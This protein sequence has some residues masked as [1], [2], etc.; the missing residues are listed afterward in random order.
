MHFFCRERSTRER[1]MQVPPWSLCPGLTSVPE[2]RRTQIWG[3]F[4]P[5]SLFGILICSPSLGKGNGKRRGQGHRGLPVLTQSNN[6]THSVRHR[7]L[8]LLVNIGSSQVQW[9]QSVAKW[10]SRCLGMTTYLMLW[11]QS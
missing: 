3:T 1:N 2:Q 7:P 6:Y 4:P 9:Q 5:S 11:P 10:H 8:S